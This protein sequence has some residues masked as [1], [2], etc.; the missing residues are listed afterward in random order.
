MDQAMRFRSSGNLQL[1]DARQHLPP[2]TDS[3][4]F[5]GPSSSSILY[6]STSREF[7]SQSSDNMRNLVYG[8]RTR[9]GDGSRQYDASHKQASSGDNRTL[10]DPIRDRHR[11][12]SYPG[13]ANEDIPSALDFHINTFPPLLA[14]DSSA[15]V[16]GPQDNRTCFLHPYPS[17]IQLLPSSSTSETFSP[18]VSLSDRT[19][20]HRQLIYFPSPTFSLSRFPS[21]LSSPA[22]GSSEISGDAIAAF[23]SNWDAE[24]II[25]DMIPISDECESTPAYETADIGSVQKERFAERIA[26]LGGKFKRALLNRIRSLKTQSTRKDNHS[27][28]Y[29]NSVSESSA[30]GPPPGLTVSL[31]FPV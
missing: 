31:S 23:P 1:D 14:L 16:I 9:T 15:G 25:V 29:R 4:L 28:H 20:I 13:L 10:R 3:N 19:D 2:S 17:D 18:L 26:K 5:S 7:S 12:R 22:V 24:D 8:E 21:S 27:I 30:L 11:R 6:S